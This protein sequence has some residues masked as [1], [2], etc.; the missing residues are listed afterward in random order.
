MLVEGFH[1]PHVHI[2]MYPVRTGENLEIHSGPEVSNEILQ[3]EAEK[4]KAAL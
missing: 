2:K 1:V 4:I 3:A